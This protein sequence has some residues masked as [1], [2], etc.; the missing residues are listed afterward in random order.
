MDDDV[1][2]EYSVIVTILFGFFFNDKVEV[3]KGMP[4]KLLENKKNWEGD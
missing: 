4:I 2:L 3:I 1:N